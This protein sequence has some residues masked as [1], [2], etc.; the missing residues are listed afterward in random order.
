MP[1]VPLYSSGTVKTQLYERKQKNKVALLTLSEAH[2]EKD[3]VAL[4]QRLTSDVLK[5]GVYLLLLKGLRI[6]IGSRLEE[7]GDDK[8][9]HTC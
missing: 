8:R 4:G 5:V 2:D 9:I 6:P 7:K 1:E 3:E